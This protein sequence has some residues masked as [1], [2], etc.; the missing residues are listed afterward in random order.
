MLAVCGQMTSSHLGLGITDE[1]LAEF[2][3]P[4]KTKQ[5]LQTNSFF[6]ENKFHS[7]SI[8]IDK[9]KIRSSFNKPQQ[10]LRHLMEILRRNLEIKQ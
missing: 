4:I 7:L 2:N 8:S 9:I 3:F 6:S 1:L 5:N 10:N